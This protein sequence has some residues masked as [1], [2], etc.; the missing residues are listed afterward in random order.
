MDTPT[1]EWEVLFCE[2]CFAAFDVPKRPL[3]K[4][5]APRTHCDECRRKAQRD[6]DRASRR[7]RRRLQ[8][9]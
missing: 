2:G 3:G 7:R 9:A 8:V 4:A 5:G 6:Y 1:I